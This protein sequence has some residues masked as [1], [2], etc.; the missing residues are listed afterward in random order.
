MKP[1]KAGCIVIPPLGPSFNTVASLRPALNGAQGVSG[2]L[3][4]TQQASRL[5]H[6]NLPRSVQRAWKIARRD[7]VVLGLTEH[8]LDLR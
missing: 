3:R 7:R 5:E 2:Q 8:L 6:V 1:A 4:A